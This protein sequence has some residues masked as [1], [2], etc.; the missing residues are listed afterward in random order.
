MIS[1]A[2]GCVYVLG[3]HCFNG[4]RAVKLAN[5]TDTR[6]KFLIAQTCLSNIYQ[7]ESFDLCGFEAPKQLTLQVN[8]G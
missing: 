4:P 8:K 2:A 3:I 6:G 7:I 1:E 5:N